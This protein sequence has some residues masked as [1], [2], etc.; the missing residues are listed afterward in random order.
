MS[1]HHRKRSVPPAPS[2]SEQ[3]ATAKRNGTAARLA[4]DLEL[5]RLE[6]DMQAHELLQA[7][8]ELVASSERYLTLYELSP[9]GYMT[10]DRKGILQELNLAMAKLL[11]AS[12][13]Q[14]TGKPALLHVIPADRLRLHMFIQRC[15]DAGSAP[16]IELET[17]PTPHRP[18][19]TLELQGQALPSIGT[20]RPWCQVAAVDVTARKQAEAQQR[21]AQEELERRVAERTADLEQ[22]RRMTEER[23]QA[24]HQA[25][26]ALKALTRHLHQA[27]EAESARIAREIHDELGATLTAI[28]Y[29]LLASKR[30][31]DTDARYIS[32]RS[33]AL[34]KLVDDA[35]ESLRRIITDLR[36]S[37]LDELGLYGALEWLCQEFQERSGI[38]CRY[39]VRGQELRLEGQQAT[40]IFRI[41]QEAL[42]N[43]ARHAQASQVEVQVT[44]TRRRGCIEVHDNGRGIDKAGQASKRG[45]GLLGMQERARM[46]NG[47]VE[48]ASAPGAGTTV[49]LQFAIPGRK[50]AASVR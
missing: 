27:K 25:H 46:I 22:A 35:I 40:A 31:E 8:Q 33:P 34:V 36:P 2:W 21:K 13:D 24:L 6:L 4:H 5:H 38:P 23:T 7:Q 32:G 14:L 16:P 26:Q 50:A 18:R 43:A 47:S 19:R 39:T 1:E 44:T 9:V 12:K 10:L 29:N 30:R 42:T 37:V 49:R 45:F 41:I 15:L 28:K 20:D 48:I 17:R 3:P 11:G